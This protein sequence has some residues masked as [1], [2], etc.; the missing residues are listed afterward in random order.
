MITDGERLRTLLFGA[1]HRVLLCAPFIKARVLEVVLSVVSNSV[2]VRIVTRW[3]PKE[4][5]AG[6]SDLRVFEVANGRPNTDL[7]LFDDLHAK[8]Y[9]ADDE[10]LVGSANLTA[11]ALGWTE[12]SNVEL[13]VPVHV[14][15][16]DVALLLRRL[17]FAEAATFTRR[18]EVEKEAAAIANAVGGVTTLDEGDDI[19]EWRG[20]RMVA[21]LPRC[22]T[23][24]RLYEIYQNHDATVV[25]E[26]TKEDGEADLRDLKVPLGLQ[27]TA[28]N[29]VV[30]DT[31][32]VMPAVGRVLE[33][34]PRGVTDSRGI[35]LVEE[36]RPGL[37]AEDAS[38]QWR[39]VR[40]WIGVF[41]AND[42]GVAPA[43]YVTRLR[44]R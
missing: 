16:E 41:F 35:A 38:K 17:E 14:A 43:S 24:D 42:F 29:E 11:S 28:F 23:P 22:A 31:L 25:A 39:I 1:R 32:R 26:G 2:P 3:R 44:T 8:V 7:A 6:V 21:W 36:G 20:K 5:A 10:C 37:A 19:A 15:D 4:V 18:S 9:V 34:V 13:L 30:R 27:Q 12:R 33:E 40:D